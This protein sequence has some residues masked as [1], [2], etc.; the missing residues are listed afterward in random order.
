MTTDKSRADALTEISQFLTDVV[1]A[2]SLLSHGRTDKKL[3]MRVAERAYELRTHMHRLAASPVEQREAAPAAVRTEKT[4]EPSNLAWLIERDCCEYER[5]D[6]DHED[7]ICISVEGLHEVVNR[8]VAEMLSDPT[9]QPELPAA[10]ERAAFDYDD[11]VSI[12]DAH[13]IG[14]PVDCVEMV[15]DIVKLSGLFAAGASSP[16]AAGAE[17]ADISGAYTYSSVQAT[18]CACCGDYKHTPLRIDWMGG[19][20]CLTCIDRE[21]ESRTSAQAAEPVAIQAGWKLV[22][23]EPTPGMRGAYVDSVASG[24]GADNVWDAMITAAP[25]PA[26][27]SSPVGL[28]DRGSHVEW[29]MVF[30]DW[31]EELVALHGPRGHIASGLTVEQARAIINAHGGCGKLA[32]LPASS[33]LKG[34]KHE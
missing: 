12:C 23:I 21:L 22:P 19:Y 13:G 4:A 16:N 7:T 3:A 8:H 5:A 20:V 1:T 26:P 25:P 9:S 29:H 27:A 18:N 30:G 11:V 10:D 32:S 6:P 34:A 15:V 33:L 31:K 28:T 2:A 14:L 24:A 17:G